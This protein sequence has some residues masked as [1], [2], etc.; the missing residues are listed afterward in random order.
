MTPRRTVDGGAHAR[1]V[2][3]ILTSEE[4]GLR[5]ADNVGPIVRLRYVHGD[6][7]I[8]VDAGRLKARPASVIVLRAVHLGDLSEES[9]CR[10]RW[11][12]RG[13]LLRIESID[14]SDTSS[15]YDVELGLLKGGE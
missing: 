12:W 1:D 6:A 13:R 7:P 11:R 3:Q 4:V 15:S 10:V 9:G 8:D 2:R 14:V 5:W